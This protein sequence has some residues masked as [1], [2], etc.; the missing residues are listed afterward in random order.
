[1][2]ACLDI[3]LERSAVVIPRAS[4]ITSL[5]ELRGK[6][7]CLGEYNHILKWNVPVG[8]LLASE[9]MVPD[10][11]G[12]L[13][14]VERFFSESCAAGNWSS[15][16]ELDDDLSEF[17]IMKLLY[18]LSDLTSVFFLE[19]SHVRLCSLCKDSFSPCSANDMFSGSDGTLK[20]L[21]D[22]TRAEV[23]FTTVDIAT[24]FFSRRPE[25]REQFEFLCLDGSRMAITS[26]GCDWAKHPT[27]S[28]VIRKGR[29]LLL[30]FVI[31]F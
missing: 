2:C 11:R 15:D 4:R 7:A 19:K 3:H 12:E 23:A 29:G 21:V 24:D 28:F 10:C 30:L 14:S 26:R 22:G 13:N 1:M 25:E 8:I 5:S 18:F 16:P 6:R 17:L 9:T 27:N 31:F 20:C